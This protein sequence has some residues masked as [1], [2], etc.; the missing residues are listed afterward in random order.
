MIQ[1]QTIKI[2][3][4]DKRTLVN[5]WLRMPSTDKKFLKP[6]VES[7]NDNRDIN[8]KDYK[9]LRKWYYNDPTL[10]DKPQLRQIFRAAI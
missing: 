8:F 2:K 5:E 3:V 7:I 9:D 10:K 1:I 6:L 4:Q